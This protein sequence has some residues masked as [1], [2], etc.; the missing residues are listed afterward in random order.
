MTVDD[1]LKP[2]QSIG[3]LESL[4]LENR[5]SAR[6]LWLRLRQLIGEIIGLSND[7]S[8][9][10]LLAGLWAPVHLVVAAAA[11]CFPQVARELQGVGAF[12]VKE[13]VREA[14]VRGLPE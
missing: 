2:F 4:D 12:L 1:Y 10:S 6:R 7:L 5:R 8:A 3:R 13:V 14:L 11:R 9:S